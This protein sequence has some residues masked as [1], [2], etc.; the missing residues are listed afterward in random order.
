MKRECLNC[1]FM[2]LK[3]DIC[4]HISTQEMRLNCTFMELKS[5]QMVERFVHELKS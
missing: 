1:T 3:S 2:E 5:E 4:I